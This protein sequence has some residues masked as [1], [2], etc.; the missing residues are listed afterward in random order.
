MKVLLILAAAVLLILWAV[1]RRQLAREARARPQID[2]AL[3]AIADRVAASGEPSGW[4]FRMQGERGMGGPVYGDVLC[5]DGTYLPQ[6]WESD[7]CV[8][9][10]GRWLRTGFYDGSTATL[11]DRQSRRSWRIGTAQAQA[12][13][14]V[15]HGLPRWS[16]AARG[17]AGEREPM[18]NEAFAAWLQAR[19]FGPGE[20]LV[21]V[22]DLWLVADDV[23]AGAAI[24]PPALAPPPPGMAAP[25]LSLQGHWPASLRTLRD[26]LQIFGHPNWQL[27]MDGQP[28]PWL[29]HGSPHLAWRG[30]GQAFALYAWPEHEGAEGVQL[31]LALWSA[32]GG[33]QSWDERMPHDRKSWTV[34]PYFPGEAGQPPAL[35][36]DGHA[37][38]QRMELDTPETDRLHDG[39]TLSLVCSDTAGCAG[40]A[41]DGRVLQQPIPRLRFDWLRDP[42]Q[43][44]LWQA[45]SAPVEG[46]PLVWTLHRDAEDAAGE[47]AAYHLRWGGHA[48]PGEWALEHLIVDGRSALLMPHDRA[49]ER[50]GAG[51]LCLW[52]GEQLQRLQLP[53]PVVRLVP[54]PGLDGDVAERAA[55]IALAAC[56]ADHRDNASTATW[57]WAQQAVSARKLARDDHSPVYTVRHIAPDAGGH[58]RVLP[59]W[60]EV[61]R[62]QHPCADGDYVWHTTAAD[63][64]HSDALWWWGG[65]NMRVNNYWSEDEPRFDGVCVTRSGAM[66]CGTG[67]SA[68]PHPEGQG[69]A[70]LEWVERGY[71]EPDEWRL[72][73]LQPAQQQVLSL[74]LQA[75]MPL[76]QGWDEQG[77]RWLE[78]EPAE[79]EDGGTRTIAPADWRQ[80]AQ[81]R[82]HTGPRGLW[83]RR[84]DLRYTEALLARDDWP[85]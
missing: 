66:L 53:W 1:G 61:D 6:V 15:H 32:E 75:R 36:W 77:L 52:D 3:A 63:G 43:P 33:W 79:A 71:G 20:P 41:A 54:V 16:D 30:D 48:L 81:Q 5:D 38:A 64:L 29:L 78:A 46:R 27:L 10:D 58:W 44:G 34:Q 9:P 18:R 22:R 7:L 55:V 13:D 19:D 37:V 24:E 62:I 50:G 57:R 23:P 31:T 68:C 2:E 51:A 85:W 40:H 17:H 72:H 56:V 25:V 4:R 42:A 60:R 21:A 45:R 76:L 47:T 8:S 74:R 59:R 65:V 73:W 67:P 70:T 80:A 84:Q 39:C 12:L 82:L 83:L 35:R 11:V 28:Q 69:W 14:E 26:P 49:P